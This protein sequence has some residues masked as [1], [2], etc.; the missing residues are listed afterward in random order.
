LQ[1]RHLSG[2]EPAGRGLPRERRRGRREPKAAETRPQAGRESRGEAALG[3][4]RPLPSGRAACL[5]CTEDSRAHTK[6]PPEPGRDPAAGPGTRGAAPLALRKAHRL[7]GP[8]RSYRSHLGR[9]GGGRAQDHV[10]G[11]RSLSAAQVSSR[12]CSAGRPRG[13]CGDDRPPAPWHRA[14]V[15][16]GHCA[17][18]PWPW[19]PLGSLAG[20]RAGWPH[21]G[22]SRDRWTLLRGA[23]GGSARMEGPH[24]RP[25]AGAR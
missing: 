14:A 24:P 9:A 21:S 10:N 23:A 4:R 13:C 20:L 3:A 2:A 6:P 17:A 22:A 11:L 8:P 5:Q 15:P 16:R 25:R 12:G 18:I 19:P 1:L 7:P